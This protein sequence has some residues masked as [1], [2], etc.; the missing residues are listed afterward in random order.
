MDKSTANFF[1]P[2]LNNNN[3]NMYNYSLTQILIIQPVD[4]IKMNKNIAR[5]ISQQRRVNVLLVR[6]RR[7]MWHHCKIGM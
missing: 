2:F 6:Q 7:N 5:L 4:M 3:Q 1:A